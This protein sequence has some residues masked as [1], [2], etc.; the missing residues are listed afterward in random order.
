VLGS[1][2]H[3]LEQDLERHAVAAALVGDEK[4]AV[5]MVGAVLECNCV[6]V[7]V[8]VECNVKFIELEALSFLR[9][10]LGFLQLSDHSVVH[11]LS[12][13]SFEI[14]LLSKRFGFVEQA[15]IQPGQRR[16]TPQV[17]VTKRHADM[18]VPLL[19]KV[20]EKIE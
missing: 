12:P 8:T 20:P 15:F 9:V 18:R 4:F 19:N 1:R 7:I 14:L 3:V 16:G 11:T 13:F 17:Q 10:T 6:V 2:D 5:A